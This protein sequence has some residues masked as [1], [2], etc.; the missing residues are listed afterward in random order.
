MLRR[1]LDLTQRWEIVNMD[2]WIAAA[3]LLYQSGVVGVILMAVFAFVV[4]RRL[5][6]F[7]T[8]LATQLESLKVSLQ[9]DAN[10]QL[11]VFKAAVS[12]SSGVETKRLE[13]AHELSQL[14]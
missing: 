4:A 9:L 14:V 12:Q 6:C 5:E 10:K 3:G 13:A 8:D 7:K 11:E 2:P 1:P